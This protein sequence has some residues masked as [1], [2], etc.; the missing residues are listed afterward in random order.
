[1]VPYTST[2]LQTLDTHLKS[3]VISGDEEI[4]ALWIPLV[5]T[6]K[7]TLTYDDGGML[8][9]VGD[10]EIS[11]TLYAG[12]WRDD[13]LRQISSPVIQQVPL[14]TRLPGEND[15]RGHLQQCLEAIVENASDETLLKA[16]NLDLLMHT[17]SENAKVRQFALTCSGSLW[18][19]HGG[20]LL[21]KST[22]VLQQLHVI[23][24]LLVRLRP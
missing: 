1:M 10:P 8:V 11:L 9:I 19:L 6:L 20:K 12:F 23:Y 3:F 22:S 4:S 14:C 21:G 24:A 7:K 13:K 15:M 18:R 17:R 5:T 16:I 2:L